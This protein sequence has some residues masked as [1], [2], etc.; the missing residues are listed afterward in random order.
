[1]QT[2]IVKAQIEIVTE[3]K[4]I[5]AGTKIESSQCALLDK[6][7]IR[8]FSYKMNVKKVYDDGAI[9]GADILDITDNV[10]LEN[11][12]KGIQNMASI[13][14]ASNYITKPAVP[15]LM[16]N[17]FKNLAAVTF[18]SDYTFKQ[19]EALKEAAKN[20]PVGGGSA[21]PAK[22]EKKEAPKEEEK[23]EEEADVDMGG[24]F[25]DEY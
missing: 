10:I 22:Q 1:M 9:Y 12:S 25:G 6:L 3:K 8:P 18:V 5:T 23:V 20:A 4:V 24:L 17:A 2:K 15:H 14:L 13:S 21:G 19:A 11:F 16:A 7:K